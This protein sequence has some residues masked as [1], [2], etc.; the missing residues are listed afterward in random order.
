MA[1]VKEVYHLLDQKAPFAYQLGFD[2]AGFLL[3]RQETEVSRILVALDLTD[4]V[5]QEAITQEVQL[6]V[7]H[8]PLIWEK[9]AAVTDQDPVGKLLLELVEHKIALIATHTNLD[10]VEGGV[11]S[12]LAAALGLEDTQPLCQDGIDAQ[13]RP[14]GIG[15][16]GVRKETGSLTAFAQEVKAALHVEGLRLMDT[17][18]PVFRVAV[19]GG[20]CGGM[21]SDVLR[22][23]CDTFVT[24]EIKHD[25]YLD[26]RARGVNLIDAGHYATEALVCS[27]LGDWL[28]T[29][30]P[31]IE[32]SISA[33]QR[34]V[35]SYA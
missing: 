2:N 32:V 22:H 30:F 3:G 26:A 17:G 1:S 35:F 31:M 33:A 28:R 25:V 8:H 5:L 4:A 12:V 15:R 27:V 21:L 13:G 18:R 20:A 34:E 6:V 23:G 24:S 9:R 10:A 7:T 14:Y 29:A 19:G 16:V 11:N